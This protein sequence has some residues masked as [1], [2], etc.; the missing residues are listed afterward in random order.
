M[1]TIVTSPRTEGMVDASASYYQESRVFQAIQNTQAIEYDRIYE[2]NEELDLQLSPITATWGLSF[3]EMAVGLPPSPTGDYAVRRPL[4]LARMLNEKNFGADTIKELA[5]NYGEKIDVV[6]D[7]T[8]ATVIV[9]F[10]NGIPP[11]L[12]DFKATI[13]GLIHAHMGINYQFTYKS[14]GRLYVASRS[15]LAPTLLVHPYTSGDYS[16]TNTV[17]VVSRLKTGCVL[18]V[19]GRKEYPQNE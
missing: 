16:T 18:L 17:G 10:Y 5:A 19:N 13:E 6:I 7:H 8:T 1:N 4:I 14:V 9:T 2:A 12:N 15:T 3:W 11:F